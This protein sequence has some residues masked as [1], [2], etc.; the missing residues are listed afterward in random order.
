MKKSLHELFA[1]IKIFTFTHLKID[2]KDIPAILKKPLFIVWFF[3][4][5]VV[6]AVLY[7]SFL[8]SLI[9]NLAIMSIALSPVA[10]TLSLYFNNVRRLAKTNY[11]NYF[12]NNS[13]YKI[14]L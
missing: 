1:N 8:Y 4:H 7:H 2:K 5:I 3:L 9:L 13:S 11:R 12:H 6:L 10:E 14:F